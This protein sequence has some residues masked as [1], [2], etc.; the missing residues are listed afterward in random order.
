MSAARPYAVRFSSDEM[1][2]VLTTL[3]QCEDDYRSSR[4]QAKASG[5]HDSVQL[6]DHKIAA[7]RNLKARMFRA[8]APVAKA[9]VSN[10]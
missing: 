5:N 6:C 3:W 2:L 4:H 9:E 10:A 8:K 7:I 1:D